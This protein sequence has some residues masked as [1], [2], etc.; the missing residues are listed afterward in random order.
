MKSV[1]WLQ[2]LD[3]SYNNL[4]PA[5]VLA[6]GNLKRLRQLDISA[7]NLSTLPADLSTDAGNGSTRYV[8]YSLNSTA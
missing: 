6:L 1:Y 5:D 7:N 3:L 4:S 2:T 8:Y